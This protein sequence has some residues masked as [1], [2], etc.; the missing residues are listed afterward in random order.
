MHA[1]NPLNT[2][3][4][5]FGLGWEL[6]LSQFDGNTRILSLSTGE[7]FKVTGTVGNRLDMPE[8]K[9]KSFHFYQDAPDLYRVVHKSG[10]IEVLRAVNGLALPEAIY[11]AEGHQVSLTYVPFGSGQ[12]RLR[13]VTDGQGETLLQVNTAGQQIEVLLRPDGTPDGA[14]ARF[15]MKLR[16]SGSGD[17]VYEVVLPGEDQ[18]S[19]RFNYRSVN[20]LLCI[21]EV[22]T[23]VGGRETIDYAG[24]G[25]DFPGN[26]RPPLP[27]VWKHTAYPGFG[28]PA[29]EVRYDYSNTNLPGSSNNFLG[30]NAS[31]SWADDGQDNL[32]KVLDRY[33]YGTTETDALQRTTGYE[34][35]AF[36]RMVR[37]TLPDQALVERRYAPHSTE[38]LP[39]WIGV[40]DRELGQQAFDGL[41]RMHTSITGG[42]VTTYRFKPGQTQACKVIRPSLEEIDYDYLPA[43]GE[44]PL[45]RTLASPGTAATYDYDEKNARLRSSEENGL[46]LSREYFST[47]EIKSE[48]RKEGAGEALTM[49][50]GYSRQARLLTYT[51]VLE[52]VQTYDYDK[53]SGQLKGTRLG[54][55]VAN[56]TYNAQGQ[57]E[58][59]TT[60]DGGQSLTTT[61][62]YDDQGR[63][64][65][66]EFD[67]GAGRIQRLSQVYNEGDLLVQRTLTEGDTL[68][69]DETYDYDVRG[70]L[71][72]Y[73]C[74]GT[75]P[76]Q[77]PYG[78]PIEMQL[79]IF[80]ELDNLLRVDTYS[81]QG[82]LRATYHYNN[83]KDPAQLSEVTH[84]LQYE[85]DNIPEKI[86]LDYDADGNLLH[87]EAGRTLGYDELGRLITVSS[88]AGGPSQ[89]H[90]DPLDTLAGQEGG[91]SGQERRFYA[92]GKLANQIQAD[93]SSTFMR[94]DPRQQRAD[95]PY[96]PCMVVGQQ[97]QDC[98]FALSVCSCGCG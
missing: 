9:L 94:G 21:T 50:Y 23:P 39:V 56:F 62:T 10:L 1:S 76:P 74:S 69:R 45:K 75:Q 93:T 73:N 85:D 88:G 24:I 53:H 20:D 48:T 12:R 81:P 28:Q 65:L 91:S 70:R 35:D 3:D 8:Q 44:D 47:G 86:T 68:L 15:V 89:Y 78:K 41:D 80:D 30:N 59:I 27:R 58:R 34:Y 96:G 61:L 92:D 13:S 38:D 51:D 83:E 16:N 79:F 40:N 55:T 29:L 18:P 95:G 32:Y 6:R 22:K 19:W 5:G 49:F 52:Q 98:P 7:T 31:I 2:Q 43:L 84:V 71:E 36:E 42:R 26:A 66:R 87:D 97:R 82:R 25:H 17:E 11:S 4:N 46:I 54:T 60:T 14:L 57:T 90:Y 64:V 72:A 33:R 63:E 37:S 77:D 67:F